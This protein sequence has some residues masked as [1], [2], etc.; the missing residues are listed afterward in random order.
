MTTTGLFS[1]DRSAPDDLRRDLV[2][3]PAQHTFNV[4]LQNGEYQITIIVGDQNYLHDQI[5]VYAEGTLQLSGLSNTAGSFQEMTFYATVADNQLNLMIESVGGADYNWVVN[6]ITI[7]PGSPTLPSEGS[8][9]FGTSTSPVEAGYTRVTQTTLYAPSLGYGWVTTTGLFSVD[10]SAPDDLR[11]D[12][13]YSATP[14]TFNVDLQNGDYLVTV[15]VGDQTYSHDKINIYAEGTLQ[16]SVLSAPAGSFHEVVFYV[17]VTDS[18]LNLNIE[19]AGG[20]DWN[21]VINT[22]TIEEGSLVLPSEGSFDFGTSTSPVEA[23]YTGVTQTTLYAPSLGYG[24]V[25]TTGLFSVDRSAPDDLRGDLVYSATPHTFNVDLQNGDDLVT[26]IT[27]GDQ[28]YSH[29]KINIYAEGT[30]QG[31][32][33]WAPAGSFHE[34]VFYVTVTDSQLNLNIEDAGGADWN[35]VINTITIEEGSLVLPSEGSFDFGTSTSPVEAGYTRVTQTTLYAPSLG[36]GWVTTTG[37]FSVHRSAPDDLRGD[38]VYSATPHTFNVD[39]QNGDY[40]VTVTVGDQ[41]YSH[42]KINIYAEGTLQGSVLSAPAGS[43]HEVVFYVTVTDSQLNLNIEDAGGAD[44]NWVINTITIEE[45]S[46]V[47]PSEGS[48]DFGTSTSPVEAGYTRVTQTTLYA[49][50][51]GYGWVTTTGLFSVDRSAPDDLRG[52]L[53]YS[54]TP[55]TFNVDL[56]NGDYLVTVTVGDQTYSHDKINIYA[57]GTLQGSVLSAPAGSFHEVVFYVTV[58]D[59]QLNLNIEDAGGADWNWVI[60][61][62]TILQNI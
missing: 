11:G 2:Y 26:V 21:W 57:E 44:W 3:G 6:A 28:T 9:D 34:V 59:S 13:V 10:R 62:I 4:D 15:T 19:D 25:T 14:H 53:V 5:S 61:T 36:Y 31:S 18:Q 47:L 35:W 40:L 41:T 30:L 37:L 58:T 39:L 49:P 56:Q 54:A 42:D 51:L 1:V 55:H 38:L 12:L 32:V 17:T 20:A 29:D 60:N 16:G 8:F 33:L 22:I 43:F 50:S 24:W 46:L 52:D 45:G 7:V 27:V 48:F 23:G